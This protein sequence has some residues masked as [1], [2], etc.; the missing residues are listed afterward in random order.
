MLAAA[1]A[2]LACKKPLMDTT[3]RWY[4]R[5]PRSYMSGA[6]G[7]ADSSAWK[8]PAKKGVYVAAVR[9]PEWADWKE[10]DF[11]G[12]EAVLF[13][14][15]IEIARCTM[16]AR[17]DP[18][19]IRIRDGHLWTDITSGGVTEIYCD[20]AHRLTIPDE[21]LL[22]GFLI[23]ND[24]LHTLGQRPGGGGICYRI[25]GEEVFSSG[26]GTVAGTMERDSIGLYYVYGITIRKGESAQTEYH[27]MNRADE[28]K[29]VTP[30]ADGLIYDIRVR[31]GTVYRSERRNDNPSSLC[32]VIGDSFHSMNVSA[33]EDIRQCKLIELD[34]EMMIKGYTLSKNLLYYWIRAR[35][36]VR[37]QV[38][39][40]SSAVSDI[41]A[42]DGRLAYILTNGD[43]SAAIIRVDNKD[44]RADQEG[45][46]LRFPG[47]RC[48]DYRDGFFAAALSDTSGL[49]HRLFLGDRL[50]PLEFNGYFTSL[51]IYK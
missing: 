2:F 49:H 35:D 40:S 6:A 13:R 48:A 37:H 7:A 51:T 43:G 14:D 15:S 44:F 41:Y 18:D 5:G 42:D 22:K 21:E 32:L 20:G 39:C 38:V 27:I 10:G 24:T 29:T 1:A 25:N 4:S 47:S 46:C 33:G 23:K 9:F 12:A 16:G 26:A 3:P 28:I 11:R 31:G 36:G 30:N 50:V 45:L 34:G 8:T 17:P 19:R